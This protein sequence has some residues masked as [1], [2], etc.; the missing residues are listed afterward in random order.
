MTLG[1]NRPGPPGPRGLAA[2]MRDV[3]IATSRAGYYSG[4]PLFACA[5]KYSASDWE[6]CRRHVTG[7]TNGRL[8]L[9]SKKD[10]NLTKDGWFREGVGNETCISHYFEAECRHRGTSL[11]LRMPCKF[12]KA[13]LKDIYCKYILLDFS[14]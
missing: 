5:D 9:R 4:R 2:M 13:R 8:V 10:A 6:K 3:L 12:Q 11:K 14:N 7:L 1:W